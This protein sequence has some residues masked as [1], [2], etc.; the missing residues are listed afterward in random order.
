MGLS[1]RV[2]ELLLELN[3]TGELVIICII[4]ADSVSVMQ[5]GEG[6]SSEGTDHSGD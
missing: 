6:L 1:E 4:P 5:T 3:T 2:H